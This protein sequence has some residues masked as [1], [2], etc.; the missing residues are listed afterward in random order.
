MKALH[1]I[2]S[3]SPRYGGPSQALAQMCKALIALGVNTQ[4]ASTDAEPGG[5]IAVDLEKP[6]THE[7]VPAIFFKKQWSEAFKY[8]PDLAHWLSESVSRFDV[9]HI[10][11]VFSHACLAAARACR[12]HGIPYIIRPLGT[13]DP[14]SMRRRPLRKRLLWH[15]G[16]GQMLRDAAAI[17]YTTAEERRQAEDSLRLDHGVV[18]PHG[19]ETESLQVRDNPSLFRQR[20]PGL[21]HAPYVLVLS[22]LHPK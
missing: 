18:I 8:S 19:I 10:H 1:V 9:V 3:V 12:R 2:P 11:A 14:W 20:H 17:H 22:R 7:G 13:L 5:R 16:V 6:T 21:D 15:L 4:I